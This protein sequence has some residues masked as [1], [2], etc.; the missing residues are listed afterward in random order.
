MTNY[1]SAFRHYM[2]QI[3]YQ[4]TN[5]LL[6]QPNLFQTKVTQLF[7]ILLRDI[8]IIAWKTR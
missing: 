6:F 1:V 8:P 5:D 7:F 4:T 3:F 2:L